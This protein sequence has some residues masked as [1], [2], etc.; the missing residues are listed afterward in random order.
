MEL[1]RQWYDDFFILHT[2]A[3]NTAIVN[4]QS[5]G[6]YAEENTLRSEEAS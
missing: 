1:P 2:K 4:S 6:G 5:A 3:H